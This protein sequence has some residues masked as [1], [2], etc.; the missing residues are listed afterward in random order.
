MSH[1]TLLRTVFLTLG[2][3]MTWTG[4]GAC[5]NRNR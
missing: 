4:R 3:S 2:K 1:K 5:S